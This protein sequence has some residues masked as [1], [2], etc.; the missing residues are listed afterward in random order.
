MPLSSDPE[1]VTV[2]EVS[3]LFAGEGVDLDLMRRA[4]RLDALPEN[5]KGAFRQRIEERGG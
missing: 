3:E 1:G 2:A 5:W 4:V